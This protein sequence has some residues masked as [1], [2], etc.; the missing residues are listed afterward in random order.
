MWARGACDVIV[1]ERNKN[2]A[3]TDI[4]DFVERVDFDALNKRM[5]E[6]L[7]TAGAFD[8]LHKN[9]RQIFDNVE[10]LLKYSSTVQLDRNSSQS[11]LFGDAMMSMD[12]PKL[13]AIRDYNEM[14][15]LQEEYSAIGFYLS[16]HPLSV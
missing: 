10:Y 15:R 14:D 6:S 2:G 12:R 8:S 3:F 1:A 13:P 9:R 11:N 4:Y 7:A 5:L 16:G